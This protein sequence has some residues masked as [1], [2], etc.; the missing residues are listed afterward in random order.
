M[1][2]TS[3]GAKV[4]VF[5]SLLAVVVAVAVVLPKLTAKASAAPLLV[6]Q[7]DASASTGTTVSAALPSAASSGNLIIA[8]VMWANT[9]TAALSDSMGNTYASAVG[10][11]RA[12]GG[13]AQVFYTKNITGGPDTIT[14][15]FSQ[16]LAANAPAHIYVFEYSG[17]DPTAPLDAVSSASGAGASYNSGSAVTTGSGDLLFE[18]VMDAITQA[19]GSGFNL[20]SSA[21]GSITQDELTTTPGSYSASASGP[22]GPWIAQ[23]AAFKA[24]GSSGTPGTTYYYILSTGQ[25]LSVGLAASPPITLTQPYHNLMFNPSVEATTV[26]L[27]PLYES[28]QGSNYNVETPSSGIANSLTGYTSTTTPFIVGLDGV[29]GLDYAALKKGTTPYQTGITQVTNATNYVKN[30]LGGNIVPIAITNIHGETDYAEGNA[31]SYESYLVQWQ[32]DYQTDINSITG[33]SSTIPMF[34]NQMNSASTGELAQAQ[35]QAHIDNPGNIILVG[36]KYQYHYYTDN[37]HLTN[38]SSKAVGEMLAKVINKVVFQHQVWNPLMPTSIVRQNNVITVSYAIPVGT[39]AIDT[40]N[41]AQ[42]PSDGFDFVQTGGNSVSISSVALTNNNTQVS[43]TLSATPTGTSQQLRYAWR[44]YTSATSCGE[45][46]NATMVGGNIRDTDSS[47]SPA[48]NGTGLPLYDWGVAFDEPVTASTTVDAEPPSAPTNLVASPISTS[49]IDLSWTPS[50]D[51]VGVAGYKVFRNGTQVATSTTAAYADAGLAASTTYSYYVSAFDAAGNVSAQSNTATATTNAQGSGG[52]TWY[53]ASWLYRKAITV[54][55]SLVSPG[56]GSALSN[57]TVLINMTDS[58]LASHAQSSGNDILFTAADGV[59]KLNHQVESYTSSSGKLAAWINV[60][61][62]N[63]ASQST[64][65]VIYMYYGNSSAAAQQ[66]V[67]GTWDSSYLGVWHFSDNAANKTVANSVS[68]GSAGASQA[69]TNTLTTPGVISSAL[70]FNGT[71]SNVSVPYQSA[72]NFDKT[73]PYTLSMWFNTS[74]SGWQYFIA[75]SRCDAYPYTGYCI[76]IGSGGAV[77]FTYDDTS[78]REIGEYTTG[79]AFNDGRWHLLTVTYDGS[80][81]LAGVHIYVDGMLQP[82]T[83]DAQYNTGSLSTTAAT[84]LPLTIGMSSMPDAYF[85]GSLDEVRVSNVVRSAD[86]AATAYNNQN[87][88]ATFYSVSSA[89]TQ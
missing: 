59:T 81:T 54:N 64:S 45:A 83:P 35:L 28:G 21:F 15:T 85:L 20:R 29:N 50:T 89:Q 51:N 66:N 71:N 41:V 13:A 84:T 44:C 38:T 23:M 37:L 26:P 65:T 57:F 49:E 24:A 17:I 61:A 1:T 42:R 46:S 34:I 12:S 63:G 79:A 77:V 5:C 25:S 52:G 47:V 40:T 76:G 87:S 72:V 58:D 16:A 4:A 39:L 88:P 10:P 11:T 27:I 80:N 74:S 22:N 75:D 78:S 3:L 56:S 60:P 36:P 19:G 67:A 7:S 33:T 68:S 6:Q 82:A 73:K 32:S 62:L 30:T 53:N 55:R 8:Y 43:I 2:H 70:S 18:G 86:W 48:V 14:A 31:A 69:N 9:G